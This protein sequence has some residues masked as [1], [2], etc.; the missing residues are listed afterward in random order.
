MSAAA[1]VVGDQH[2]EY[3]EKASILP[4]LSGNEIVPSELLQLPSTTQNP[5]PFT[6]P[7]VGSIPDGNAVPTMFLGAFQ[8]LQMPMNGGIPGLPAGLPAGLPGIPG[9]ASTGGGI[10]GFPNVLVKK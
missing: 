8:I 10:P 6:L 2:A 3:R 9:G 1:D 5:L 4:D 7:G